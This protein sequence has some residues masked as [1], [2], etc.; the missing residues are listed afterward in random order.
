[1]I[2]GEKKLRELYPN[3]DEDQYQPAGI[4]LKL[5]KIMKFNTKGENVYGLVNGQK[6]LP[7]QEELSDSA[8]KMGAGKLEVGYM[9]EPHIPY[10]AVVDKK[11]KIPKNY[12]QRY[13]PR[14]SLLRAGV[15]VRTAIG[16]PGFNGYLSFLIINH[17][18]VPFFIQ[19]GE[20]FAQMVLEEVDG[21][22]EGYDG[23]Y[24]EPTN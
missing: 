5:G 12:L 23:D 4:D 1:M 9:L 19:K 22:M 21:V 7:K 18:D 3:L 20:R 2:V 16:D 8:I 10:I 17:L 6:Y 24:N 14:S 13:Y 15:D 11:M